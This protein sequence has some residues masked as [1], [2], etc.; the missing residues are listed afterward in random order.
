MWLVPLGVGLRAPWMMWHRV[1]WVR[2]RVLLL[3]Y[4]VEL[5]LVVE[6]LLLGTGLDAMLLLLMVVV[7]V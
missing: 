4:Q 3:L 5:L 2:R 7:V 6:G 1:S